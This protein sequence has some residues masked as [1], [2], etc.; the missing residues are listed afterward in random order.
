MTHPPS[1][2]TTPPPPPG[3]R[4]P[5]TSRPVSASSHTAPL[6]PPAGTT[7][8]PA[9]RGGRLRVSGAAAPAP[10]TPPLRPGGGGHPRPGGGGHPRPAVGSGV[11]HHTRLAA[12]ILAAV[13]AAMTLGRGDVGCD[14]PDPRGPDGW[15]GIG[16]RL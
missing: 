15:H 7:N 14:L 8:S 11:P 10:T 6:G 2:P 1:G 9:P 5:T 13:L 3:P 4:N 12:L 16:S